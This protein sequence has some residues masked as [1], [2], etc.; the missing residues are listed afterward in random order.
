MSEVLFVLLFL[1]LAVWVGSLLLD[2]A[3]Y[4]EGRRLVVNGETRRIVGYDH[5]TKVVTVDGPWTTQPSNNS[6]FLWKPSEAD[7]E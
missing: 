3:E 6:V 2:P 7:H 4:Y 1:V 5:A